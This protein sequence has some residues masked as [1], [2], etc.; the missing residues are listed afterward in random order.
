MN[1]W[2]QDLRL[3]MR[4]LRRQFSFGCF[5]MLILAIGIG[6]NSAMFSVIRTVLFQPLPYWQPGRIVEITGGATPI[7]FEE[8]RAGAHSYSDVAAYSDMQEELAL[9]GS[10]EPEMLRGARVSANFLTVLGVTPLLG[11]SFVQDEDKPGA[12]GVALISANLWQR[13]FHGNP[14]VIGDNVTLEG[15]QHTIVGV[16]PPGFQFPFSGLDVWVTKPSESALITGPSRLL[17]PVLHVV[18]RLKPG[19]SLQQADA[20]LSVL[21][22]QYSVAHPGM[23]DAKPHS[24][25][26]VTP[27]L[28]TIVFDVRPKLWLLFG[29]VGFILLIACANIG[30]LQIVR[31]NSREQEFGIR[32]A[33]GAGKL[34]IIRQL[35]A[36]N[37]LLAMLG[38]VFG[39]ILAAATLT[40][41][42]SM[43]F[44]DLPRASEIRMN[45]A[46]VAFALILSLATGIICGLSPAMKFV[47]LDL[48]CVLRGAHK[49]RESISSKIA[50][51]LGPRSVLV[52][53]QVA[54]CTVLLIGATLLLQSLTRLYQVAGTFQP[55]TLLTMHLTLSSSLYDSDLK[56]ATFYEKLTEQVKTLPGVLNAAVTLTLPMS[57]WSGSP[58]QLSNAPRLKLNERPI[59]IVQLVSPEYFSTLKIHVKRG[60][61]FTEHDDL[62]S[63]AVVI[64]SETLAR[65]FWPQYPAGPDPIG[66]QILIGANPQPIEIV[67]IVADVGQ[68]PLHNVRMEL[69]R[70][71]FQSPNLSA[72]LAVRTNGDP[73]LL[74]NAVR[75]QILGIDPAQPVSDV[76][77]MNDVVETSQ[78]Q[79]RLMARLL[80]AFAVLATVLA[81]LGLYGLISY[82]VARR[83]KEVG[84]RC[85]L[86]ASRANI[87]SLI[88]SQGLGLTLGGLAIG[89]CGAFG[90]SGLLADLLFGV[91]ATNPM[92]YFVVPALFVIVS[93]LA[94]YVPARRAARVD[95]MVALRYE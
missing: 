5:A 7:R 57:G 55:A 32:F 27:L 26:H 65:H 18:G 88:I 19:L 35:L 34:R 78:G 61:K 95:P 94:S 74:A 56:Q 8:L 47:H 73:L 82:S 20:E 92:A 83:T 93:L 9:S 91:G 13:N 90:L 11:R 3:A 86:G 58:V 22:H 62:S 48:T 28:D 40:G 77:T 45:G 50:Q 1:G 87:L 39:V 76:M 60:R 89:V 23:L 17:S 54:L 14:G 85:A 38:G 30:A 63:P 15:S 67:G 81:T 59:S 21:D 84:I 66:Q 42:R 25:E 80:T 37:I 16:L 71:C 4:Q 6:T 51:F 68:D 33:I 2:V 43:T 72:T 64:V 24:P 36:E 10:S 31:A 70:P 75:K 12:P 49:A 41:I 79:L 69:Y 46:V 29:A 44:I 52:M 53:G